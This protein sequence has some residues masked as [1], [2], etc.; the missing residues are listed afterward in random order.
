MEFGEFCI[1]LSKWKVVHVTDHDNNND[2]DNNNN[3]NDVD[4]DDNIVYIS[5]ALKPFG[6]D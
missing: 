3:S 5:L 1:I 4:D 2:N 6:M